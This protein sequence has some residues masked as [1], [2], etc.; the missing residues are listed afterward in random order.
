M[1]AIL[2]VDDEPAVCSVIK[3]MLGREGYAVVTCADG[4]AA[5]KMLPTQD[6]AAALIDL[7]LE[8]VQ[9]GHIVEAVRAAKPALP[10]IV[11]SG[12][13][14]AEDDDHMPGLPAGLDGLHRLPKPFRPGN[15]TALVAAITSPQTNQTET[16]RVAEVAGGGSF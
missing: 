8:P 7:G 13:L 16:A 14:L 4:Q 3:L 12:V 1:T 5:L 10:I 15:L 2:V 6:F 9:G 11:M